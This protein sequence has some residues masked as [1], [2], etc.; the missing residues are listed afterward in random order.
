MRAARRFDEFGVL[1]SDDSWTRLDLFMRWLPG[2]QTA[3]ATSS[4]AVLSEFDTN[5]IV[6]CLY[7]PLLGNQEAEIRKYILR[8]NPHCRL[9]LLLPHGAP[10]MR[11][12]EQY[13]AVLRRPIH[14]AELRTT[15]ETQLKCGVYSAT[16]HEFYALNAEFSSF[17]QSTT[18]S[19][20]SDGSGAALTERYHRLKARL[21]E[22]QSLLDP[23]DLADVVQGLKLHGQY[24]TEPAKDTSRSEGSKYHPDRCPTCKLPWGVDHRNDLGIGLERLGA[25]VWKCNRCQGIAHGLGDSHRRVTR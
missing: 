7:Q 13:D 10:T 18:E 2:Y 23:S 17:G 15:I 4:E 3:G 16:L 11:A 14:E 22:L 9:V 19:A 5:T 21:D 6:A 8:R 20:R 24:L 25:Y 12:E 1:L